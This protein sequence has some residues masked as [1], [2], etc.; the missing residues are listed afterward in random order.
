MRKAYF[1]IVYVI[2]SI[3]ALVVASGAPIPHSGTGGGG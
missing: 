2:L 3:A 1:T